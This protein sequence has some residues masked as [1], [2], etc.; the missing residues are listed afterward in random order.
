MTRGGSSDGRPS[1]T[2][3][4]DRHHCV[5][6][7]ST[8]HTGD[9]VWVRDAKKG[10]AV[11]GHAGPPRSYLV[12]TLTS[13]LR[14]IDVIWYLHR[15]CRWC[16]QLRTVQLRQHSHMRIPRHSHA[17]LRQHSGARLRQH[18]RTRRDLG[19][20]RPRRLHLYQSLHGQGGLPCLHDD[21]TFSLRT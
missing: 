12:H 16:R 2:E 1:N 19:R 6:P 20:R 11:V 14:A 15:T 9:S 10:G 8:L 18:S 5:R 21:W 7:L 3:E 4:C 17:R 13:C